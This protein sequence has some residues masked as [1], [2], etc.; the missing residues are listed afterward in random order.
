MSF[1][2]R[3]TS[4]DAMIVRANKSKNGSF[5]GR[6]SHENGGADWCGTDSWADA[7]A[8][9]CDGWSE[10]RGRVDA[11]AE[12]LRDRLSGKF[13]TAPD[14]TYDVC[15][16][17]VDIA[18]YMSGEPECMVSFMPQPER[19]GGKHVRICASS[20]ASA[21][22]SSDL[23]IR[24]GVAILALAEALSMV[25]ATVT[26]DTIMAA[27]RVFGQAPKVTYVTTVKDGGETVDADRVMYALAHPSF[28]RRHG[29]SMFESESDENVRAMGWDNSGHCYG[30]PSDGTAE[31]IGSYDVSVPRCATGREPFITDPAE[32]VIGQVRALGF[33]VRD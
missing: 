18:Q 24:R 1:V 2:E 10:I 33:E 15:G 14:R 29:F 23:M 32:W 16:S 22:V 8:L 13:D 11:I 21:S 28:F 31:L 25:G 12:P 17:M 20:A 26:I 27:S 4:L 7:E 6:S 3:F 5:R 9:A 19:S 30:Y